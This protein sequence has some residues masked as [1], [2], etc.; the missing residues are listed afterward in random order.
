MPSSAKVVRLYRLDCA[1]LAMRHRIAAVILDAMSESGATPLDIARVT[2]LP[3]RT[4]TNLL[5]ADNGPTL[6]DVAAVSLACGIRLTFA[7]EPRTFPTTRASLDN[8][9]GSAS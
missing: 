7:M 6:H 1:V 5:A 9:R 3:L 4:V 8:T 2:T